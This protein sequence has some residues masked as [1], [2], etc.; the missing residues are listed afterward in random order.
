VDDEQATNTA[1]RTAAATTD[2]LRT[3]RRMGLAGSLMLAFGALGAGAV[4]L[5]NPLAGLRLV[6]LPA[7]NPTISL[8]VAYAGVVLVALAWSS[9][10]LRW[11]AQQRPS[12][13]ELARAA[14]TWLA[15]LLFAPPLFSRDV[16]SYLA[17]GAIFARGLDPYRLGPAMAL[18]IDDPLVR[19]IP[20]LW[21]NTP[22]PYGPLFL[23]IGRSITDLTDKDV[24]LGVLAYRIVALA[25]LAMIV[26]ALPR[27]ARRVGADPDR[28]LWWGAANP[29]VLLHVVGGAH[30]DGLMVGLMLAG[31]EIGLAGI[32]ARRH[33]ALIAGAG[34][35]VAA[36]AVKA[37]AILA[38]AYLGLTQAR[39]RG[40]RL[41]DI[42]RATGL[43]TAIAAAIYL[44]LALCTGL[45]MG[46]PLWCES[47]CF[48]DR[49]T[50]KGGGADGVGDARGGPG[51]G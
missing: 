32:A 40:G 17:Q 49:V 41:P 37:P 39:S 4:P 10:A 27:L 18:G 11:R 2:E 30:N 1:P 14:A 21:R 16:Y 44:A 36:S 42:A 3:V 51:A 7:R 24:L 50:G 5:P 45:G 9:I 26:W 25:G 31:L 33:S 48:G 20:D 28:A 23:M 8:A 6:G 43:M 12:R 13:P 38:L 46:S 29:L 47:L 15:P 22:A 19:S 35:I 34:L